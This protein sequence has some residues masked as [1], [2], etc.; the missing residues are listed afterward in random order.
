MCIWTT[1]IS[2]VK[3]RF[4]IY[5][6]SYSFVRTYLFAWIYKTKYP[7]RIRIWQGLYIKMP[8]IWTT[9]VSEF[10]AISSSEFIRSWALI[11]YKDD[12]LPV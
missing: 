6:S 8:G 9:D 10:A 3:S 1:D 7:S 4:A 5:I 12:I 2:E 11:Q